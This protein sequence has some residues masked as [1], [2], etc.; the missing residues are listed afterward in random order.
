MLISRSGF[1]T[2]ATSTL[3]GYTAWPMFLHMRGYIVKKL[4]SRTGIAW[5]PRMT[6]KGTKVKGLSTAYWKY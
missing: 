2:L 3:L 4:E 1:A 5:G 6:Y